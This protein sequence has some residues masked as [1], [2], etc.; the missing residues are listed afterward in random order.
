[1]TLTKAAPVKKLGHS[2]A[3]S[4]F[5]RMEDELETSIYNTSQELCWESKHYKNVTEIPKL[6]NK[7]RFT[8]LVAIHV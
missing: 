2:P 1:M 5:K 4:R 3:E 7:G 6:A 8:C